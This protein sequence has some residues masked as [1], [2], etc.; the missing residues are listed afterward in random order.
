MNIEK[1]TRNI[2]RLNCIGLQ[3]SVFPATFGA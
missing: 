1:Y 2:T 3:N